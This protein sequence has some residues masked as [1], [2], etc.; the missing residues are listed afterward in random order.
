[1]NTAVALLMAT[2]FSVTGSF[3][4]S[5]SPT[6]S[7]SSSDSLISRALRS[8]LR[9]AAVFFLLLMVQRRVRGTLI[10]ELRQRP[11]SA[12]GGQ[13]QQAS[14]PIAPPFKG[15]FDD[16]ETKSQEITILNSQY[17]EISDSHIQTGT[18]CNLRDLCRATQAAFQALL[19]SLAATNLENPSRHNR[20]VTS[21]P[22]AFR[23]EIPHPLIRSV[24]APRDNGGRRQRLL[25]REGRPRRGRKLTR[26]GSLIKHPSLL[27]HSLRSSS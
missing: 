15:E 14:S 19:P 9:T 21:L 20:Q 22:L 26:F 24:T 12:E 6:F 5:E 11:T 4:F 13:L 18:C 27:S 23:R 25:R 3:G 2:F 16:E 7:S 10:K 1:M 8:G 17:P